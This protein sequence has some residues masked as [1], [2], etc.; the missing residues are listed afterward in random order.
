M[1][2]YRR[3]QEK[4]GTA[5]AFASYAA[6]GLLPIYWK[7]LSGVE[8]LQILCHRIVWALAFTLPALA[9]VGHRCGGALRV[10]EKI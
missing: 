3:S 8:S 2:D 7:R 5:L 4:L 1:N 6:W 9:A 10:Y